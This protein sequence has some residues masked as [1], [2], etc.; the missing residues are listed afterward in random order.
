MDEFTSRTAR[1]SVGRVAA[2]DDRREPA[3]GAAKDAA[4]AARDRRARTRGRSPRRSARRCVSTSSRRTSVVR[5]GVSPERTRTSSAAP[6]SAAR[7]QRTASPVPSGSSW[8]ATGSPSNAAA[9][10]GATTTTSG[11]T[12]SARADSRT[13][14]TIR[15]PRIGCRCFGTS[16]R[17]RVP[18]PAAMTTA[19]ERALTVRRHGGWGARIRTWDH[20]TKTRCLTTWPRPTDAGRSSCHQRRHGPPRR[21]ASATCA[22]RRATASAA[23][24]ASSARSNRP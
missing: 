21:G 2:L 10:A 9:V 14:S 13:Q 15:R 17:M 4:V 11:S 6:S 16:E 23:E 12:P 24:P 22:L 8:T 5:S 19:A 3:V 20:G 18:R 1:C 7:A